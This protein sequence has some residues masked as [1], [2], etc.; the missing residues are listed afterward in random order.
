M[1]TTGLPAP[2]LVARQIFRDV[3]NTSKCYSS[4]EPRDIDWAV[5]EWVKNF[6]TLSRDPE[7]FFRT[8]VL[9]NRA[10]SLGRF[11]LL[12]NRNLYETIRRRDSKLLAC[13]LTQPI[14]PE[15][16][17]NKHLSQ[18]ELARLQKELKNETASVSLLMNKVTRTHI[19]LKE[20]PLINAREHQICRGEFCMNKDGTPVEFRAPEGGVNPACS[21]FISEKPKKVVQ[22]YCFNIL[23]LVGILASGSANPYTGVEFQAET[24]ELLNKRFSLQIRLYRRYLEELASGSS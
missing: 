18:V 9:T 11:A 7:T 15:L 21:V 13:V 8:I 1:S 5:S 23:E 6:D 2:I 3:L 19:D 17:D 16:D 14:F 12:F 24:L 10:S 4:F 20:D 22:S